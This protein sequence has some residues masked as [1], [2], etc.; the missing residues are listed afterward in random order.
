M[1]CTGKYGQR[2][3]V[4][5]SEEL[6]LLERMAGDVKDFGHPEGTAIF[7]GRSMTLVIAPNGT[8]P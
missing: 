1:R 6:A 3:L 2:R 4:V 5:D 7:E 8:R